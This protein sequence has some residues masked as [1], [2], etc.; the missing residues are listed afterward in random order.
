MF[1]EYKRGN[2]RKLNIFVNNGQTRYTCPIL[3]VLI[4]LILKEKEKRPKSEFRDLNQNA[5]EVI[6]SGKP[7]N[8]I[9]SHASLFQVEFR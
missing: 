3:I 2:K 4:C 6:V 7:K 8:I 5:K 9:F 1:P